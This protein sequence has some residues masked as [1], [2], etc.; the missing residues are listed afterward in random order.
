[1]TGSIRR[2]QRAHRDVD[3]FVVEVGDLGQHLVQAAGLLA[4]R[5]H[6][7]DHR[8]EDLRLLER[9]GDRFTAGDRLRATP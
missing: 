8:R 1:M 9:R 4:D 7:D 5:D 2:E 6:R 3:F